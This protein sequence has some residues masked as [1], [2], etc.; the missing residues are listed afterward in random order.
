V[1]E[2]GWWTGMT[3]TGIQHLDPACTEIE[4]TE[5]YESNHCFFSDAVTRFFFSVI[6]K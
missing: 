6:H 3:Q 4:E 5:D 1:V 2:S